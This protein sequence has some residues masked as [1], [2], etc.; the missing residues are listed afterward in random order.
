MYD[1]IVRIVEGERDTHDRAHPRK[2]ED[3]QRNL[4]AGK[5]FKVAK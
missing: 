4:D 3:K 2:E 1:R 5:R